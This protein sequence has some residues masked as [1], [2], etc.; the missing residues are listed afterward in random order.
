M[1][2]LGE[3][4][5]WAKTFPQIPPSHFR[6]F[7]FPLSPGGIRDLNYTWNYR[8]NPGFFSPEDPSRVCLSVCSSTAPTPRVRRI[9]RISTRAS[10]LVFRNDLFSSNKS[11]LL[12][13]TLGVFARQ[14]PH[15]G[16]VVIIF[17]FFIFT[18]KLFVATF[19]VPK[20][21]IYISLLPPP[22]VL[23]IAG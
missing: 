9:P 21:I 23:Q 7:H 6:I 18:S 11:L 16:A 4:K 12:K 2:D 22:P 5:S 17:F 3:E 14:V 20:I 8:H 10:C 1:M 19:I 15:R 13:N